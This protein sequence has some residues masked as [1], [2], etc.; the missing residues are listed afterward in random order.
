[1]SIIMPTKKS[2]VDTRFCSQRFAMI[3]A[4]GI[5]KSAFWAEETNAIYL[6]TEGGLNALSV[7]KIPIRSWGDIREAYG[8]L[9]KLKQA[10]NFPYTLIVIDTIDN[11]VSYCTEEVILRAKDFYTNSKIPIMTLGDIPNGGGWART[12]ELVMIM[13]NKLRELDCAITFIGH[14][15]NK[16]IKDSVLE[17]ERMTID[18]FGSL[19]TDLVSWADHVLYVDS[20]LSGNKLSRQV[21]T[22][23]SQSKEAK[24]RG[25]MIPSGLKWGDNMAENYKAVRGVFK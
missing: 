20:Y 15:K 10:G 4:P 8:E 23:P 25:G 3:G 21:L 24:S 16:K 6:D 14:L 17:Y 22:L 18:I 12:T 9:L 1:M 5:G 7:Y 19:G 2:E 13:L 11:L